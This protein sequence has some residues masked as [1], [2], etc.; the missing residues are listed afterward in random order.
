MLFFSIYV[1]MSLYTRL[2]KEV[3]S[4]GMVAIVTSERSDMTH[5]R[6]LHSFAQ[7]VCQGYSVKEKQK[8]NFEA[9]D[10]YPLHILK[11][12]N[13]LSQFFVKPHIFYLM[14]IQSDKSSR[15]DMLLQ[16][17]TKKEEELVKFLSVNED[18]RDLVHLKDMKF[19]FKEEILQDIENSMTSQTQLIP[20]KTT[21]QLLASV[22]LADRCHLP[23][24]LEGDPGVGK[25]VAT[26]NYFHVKGLESKRINFSNSITIDS[27]FG[28]FTMNYFVE[29]IKVIVLVCY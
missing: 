18:S 16:M 26:E 21:F 20:T 2:G 25:T 13:Q 1:L 17:Q 29:V 19:L 3:L 11:K 8:Y 4:D 6:R 15:E 9:L 27:L 10:E 22:V 5:I 28:C 7:V 12:A 24:I 23:V 14:F